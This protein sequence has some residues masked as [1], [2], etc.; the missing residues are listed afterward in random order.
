MDE[1]SSGMSDRPRGSREAYEA[2]RGA[3]AEF[4]ATRPIN[5]NAVIVGDKRPLGAGPP[6]IFS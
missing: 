2:Q 3:V 4:G 5:A 6:P 1:R